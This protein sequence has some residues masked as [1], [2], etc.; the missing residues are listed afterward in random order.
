MVDQFPE[1]PEILTKEQLGVM[2]SCR[3]ESVYEACRTRS[4]RRQRFPLPHFRLFGQLRF[5]KSEIV[6]WLDRLSQERVQ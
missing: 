2:L 5:R 3:P 6:A 4:L 1:F